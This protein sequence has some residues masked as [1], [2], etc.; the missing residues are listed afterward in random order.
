MR[1][2]KFR[3]WFAEEKR[4]LPVR[5]LYQA[6][7]SGI[8]AI[9]V[10]MKDTSDADYWYTLAPGRFD[11]MQYTGLKD[12][13]A[14]EIYEGDILRARPSHV[15]GVPE[16]LGEVK[17]SGDKCSWNFGYHWLAFAYDIDRKCIDGEIIGNIYENPELIGGASV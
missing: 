4:M 2:I 15:G 14:R 13:N 10:V 12:K 1:E 9:Q 17:V 7:D 11:L 16:E 8:Y 6:E 3:T 5:E